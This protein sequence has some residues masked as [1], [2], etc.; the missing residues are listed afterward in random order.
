M[1]TPCEK[2][3]YKLGDQFKYIGDNPD[4]EDVIFT[5]EYD[6]SSKIPRFTYANPKGGITKKWV[7]LDEVTPHKFSRKR[8][9]KRLRV[10]TSELRELQEKLIELGGVSNG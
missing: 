7:S 5:F 8:L 6:D 3:G 1:A 4:F 2:L 9:E 10:L